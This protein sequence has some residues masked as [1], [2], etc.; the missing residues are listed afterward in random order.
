MKSKIPYFSQR[1][2]PPSGRDRR[3]AWPPRDLTKAGSPSH[4]AAA[5]AKRRSSP[6]VTRTRMSDSPSVGKKKPRRTTNPTT[7]GARRGV[8]ART[9]GAPRTSLRSTPPPHQEGSDNEGQIAD[10]R[11]KPEQLI[12]PAEELTFMRGDADVDDAVHQR[13]IG[14][15]LLLDLL[16]TLGIELNRCSQRAVLRIRTR[17]PVGFPCGRWRD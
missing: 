14:E 16:E 6:S 11:Q 4:A 17:D 5:G 15:L 2:H 13:A 12:E 3:A 8:R 9:G 7:D 10:R 1:N